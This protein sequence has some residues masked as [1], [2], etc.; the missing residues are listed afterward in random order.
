MTTKIHRVKM[1]GCDSFSLSPLTPP[2]QPNKKKKA[3]QGYF[4]KFWLKGP[5]GN[6]RDPSVGLNAYSISWRRRQKKD[7][8]INGKRRRR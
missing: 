5:S 6:S 7:E 1:D 4:K 2:T 8:E 3:R